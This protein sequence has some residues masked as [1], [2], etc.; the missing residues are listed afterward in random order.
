MVSGVARDAPGAASEGGP[1]LV[2]GSTRPAGTRPGPRRVPKPAD[3]N[4]EVGELSAMTAQPA[5]VGSGAKGTPEREEEEGGTPPSLAE[6]PPQEA[7]PQGPADGKNVPGNIGVWGGVAGDV[8]IARI[9]RNSR[10]GRRDC[11][12]KM[13]GFSKRAGRGMEA[14]AET[15][16]GWAWAL[17]CWSNPAASRI[18]VGCGRPVPRS[19][20]M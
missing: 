15:Q 8:E 19:S 1:V 10:R 4:V 20:M 16:S 2:K 17:R 7:S 11:Q 3:R 5:G 9:R 14:A 13:E 6:G 12:Q 18:S